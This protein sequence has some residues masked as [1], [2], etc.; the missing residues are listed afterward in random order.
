MKWDLK[1]KFEANLFSTPKCVWSNRRNA[2]MIHVRVSGFRHFC[3]FFS[4]FGWKILT[5]IAFSS[6]PNHTPTPLP[7]PLPPQHYG[8][9]QQDQPSNHL[10]SHERMSERCE[11]TSIQAEGQVSGPVLTSGFLG[12]LNHWAPLHPLPFH[13]NKT[14]AI[15][16]KKIGIWLNPSPFKNVCL[17]S[18]SVVFWVLFCNFLYSSLFRAERKHERH[19]R[20]RGRKR[21]KKKE[22]AVDWIKYSK[23]NQLDFE[24]TQGQKLCV[25][26]MREEMENWRTWSKKTETESRVSAAKRKLLSVSFFWRWYL[27]C[28]FIFFAFT[29]FYPTNAN[30]ESRDLD[31]G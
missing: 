25:T 30:Q 15:P 11:R 3:L 24:R 5:I 12:V 9:E 26:G 16:V 28:L 10:L 2:R 19:W 6:A 8:P 13:P 4:R 27:F 1:E 21:E 29:P 17:F 23:V 31:L 14:G 20:E 18:L 7:T 22:K